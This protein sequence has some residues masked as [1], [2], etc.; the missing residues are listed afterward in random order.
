[1]KDYLKISPIGGVGQ[2][3]SNC[4]LFETAKCKILID[5]G[6]LF[7]RESVFDINYLIP[8]LANLSAIDAL[9][10]THGHEDHIGAV[11]HYVAALPN[12]KIYAPKFAKELILYKLEQN[13]MTKEVFDLESH[14]FED[15]EVDSFHVNHSIPNT[16]GIIIKHIKLDTAVTFIS[17]FKVDSTLKYEPLFDFSKLE[18]L[19]NFKN[20]LA[21][22]DSTNILSKNYSTPSE[23]D[24]IPNL[25]QIISQCIGITYLTT[26]ASNIYRIQS[27]IDIARELGRVVIPHGRSMERYIEVALNTGFLTGSDIIKSSD[28]TSVKKKKIVLL[29]GCQGEF[30]GALKRVVSRQDSKFKLTSEDYV[31]FSSK[32]IPGNEKE[33]SLIYN[34][35][36]EQ[37]ANLYT[38]E[39][40]LVHVSGHPGVN[41]LKQ[42]YLALV[43]TH[44]FPIHGES[45]F[46]KEHVD[47]IKRENLCPHSQMILNG[48]EIIITQKEIKINKPSEVLEPILIHGKNIEIEKSQISQRRKLASLGLVVVSFSLESITKFKP[49]CD[50]SLQGLPLAMENN[51]ETF[52]KHLFEQFA[53]IKNLPIEDKKEKLRIFTRKYFEHNLGYRP[54]AIIH[55]C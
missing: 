40:Y 19:K 3:G 52:K 24:L 54:I 43:P 15:I 50:I 14:V 17:D 38:A 20:R 10:I 36:T 41:D 11:I 47:F 46:L 37:G 34:E 35:I 13:K 18:S 4:T 6:I 22:L 21:L 7:P 49:T 23:N 30:R 1:M 2:I 55:F 5:C 39:R 12:V 26:F 48:D 44:S 31:I 29:S 8:N 53:L 33:I 16:K 42:V 25:Y 45:F 51:V 32:A 27:V 28:D 9:I